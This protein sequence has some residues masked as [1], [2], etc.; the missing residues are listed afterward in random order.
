[1]AEDL[2]LRERIDRARKRLAYLDLDGDGHLVAAV[3][4][5]IDRP[6]LGPG[7]ATLVVA[8]DRIPSDLAGY[9]RKAA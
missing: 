5:R 4:L 1:M 6:D 9:P 3:D 2:A 8:G 7:A